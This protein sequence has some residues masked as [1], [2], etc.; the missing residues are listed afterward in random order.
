MYVLYNSFFFLSCYSEQLKSQ[1]HSYFYFE[2]T[3]YE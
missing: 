3:T 1:L 2:D